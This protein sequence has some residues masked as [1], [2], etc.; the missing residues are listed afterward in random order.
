MKHRPHATEHKSA[1]ATLYGTAC[2]CG[3]QSPLCESEHQAA[4]RYREH[5]AKEGK[6]DRAS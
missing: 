1:R 3:W 5:V 4:K 6:R 2:Y